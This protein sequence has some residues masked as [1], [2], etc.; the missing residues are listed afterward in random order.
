MQRPLQITYK[1]TASSPAFD[2]LIRDRV[3]HLERLHPRITGCRVVVEVPYRASQTAKVPL[4]VS[5][6]VDVPGRSTIVGK[7]SEERREAKQD[8]TAPL[9][10]AF[11]AIER[12][13]EK[14]AAIQRDETKTHEDAGQT[15]MIVRLFREQNY[16][17]V[18][19][20]NSP[21]LY[22]TRNAVAGGSFDEL[23]IGMMVHVTIATEE[24]PMGPQASSVRLLD[25]GKTPS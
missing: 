8:H 20:D 19:V 23:D 18:E 16:G 1:G 11:D 10:A 3:A 17:F 6:E 2:N 22:F 24:G 5:V 7:H 14:V 12:Q 21:E 15:G 13:L 4:A 9:N 25:R